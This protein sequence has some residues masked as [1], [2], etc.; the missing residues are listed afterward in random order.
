ML[1]NC[2]DSRYSCSGIIFA[3]AVAVFVFVSSEIVIRRCSVTG[4]SASG[5]ASLAE[6]L[7]T[8]Q[9]SAIATKVEMDSFF[10]IT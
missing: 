1:S 5:T 3:V 7:W 4:S 9:A 6:A 8:A 2:I 10:K